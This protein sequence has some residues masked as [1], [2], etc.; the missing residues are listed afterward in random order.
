MTNQFDQDFW[1]TVR[2]NTVFDDHDSGDTGAEFDVEARRPPKR[3]E[4]H[5]IKILPRNESI[6]VASQ[7]PVSG[8]LVRISQSS[9]IFVGILPGRCIGTS[10]ART[11]AEASP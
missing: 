8:R 11:C 7:K 5:Y 6:L 10:R 9:V 4:P 1:L 3:D 2:S